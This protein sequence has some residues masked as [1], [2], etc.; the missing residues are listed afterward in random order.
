[1]VVLPVP[2]K[3]VRMIFLEAVSVIMRHFYS[4]VSRC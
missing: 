3:P 1:M 2:I 4:W